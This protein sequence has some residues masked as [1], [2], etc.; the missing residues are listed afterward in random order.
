[1]L[2]SKLRETKPGNASKGDSST[3]KG[4]PESKWKLWILRLFALIVVPLFL[5]GGVEFIL[6]VSN[7]GHPTTFF[8]RTRV[9]GKEYYVPNEKFGLLYF[10][11]AL[12][13]SP[14]PLRM[15]VEKGSNTF[16]IFLFGES[17]AQG[18]PDPTY[19]MGRYLQVL[20]RERYPG[21]DFEVVCVAMTA[22]NSHA[23]LQIARE[24][25]G[26]QGDMWLIYMGNNEVVGPFGAGTVFGAKAPPLWLVRTSLA[27][28]RTKLGQAME[29]LVG[30]FKHDSAA[31]KSW[32]GM[33][34]FMDHQVRFD[35][36]ARLRVNH[37][38]ERNLEDI[39][40]A[41][42]RAGV[43][44]VLST[45]AS[46]LKDCAP[47]ASMHSAAF[48]ESRK[49]E[50]ETALKDGLALEG[51][52]DSWGAMQ[53]YSNAAAI[54]PQFA[55]I[56]FRLGT[57]HLAM[58]NRFW[59]GQAR[60]EFESA[61]DF[62]ALAF[63]ADSRI[64]QIIFDAAVRNPKE[65]VDLLDAA[66]L[67][68]TNSP[69]EI[70]GE[71]AFYEHVHLHFAGNYLLARAFAEHA[72]R[73]LPTSITADAKAEWATAD[74]C[75]R[76][77]GVTIWDR[78]RLWQNNMRRLFEAPFITQ[79]D[80]AIRVKSYMKKLEELDAQM[81]V[82]SPE[83]SRKIYEEALAVA[84]EDYYLHSNFGEF[85]DAIGDLP[86]AI[87]QQQGVRELLPLEPM[88][89]YKIGRALVR[90][91]KTTE[92]TEYF[93]RALVLRPD[94]VQAL[95]E[96][97]LLL[98]NQQK[99]AEAGPY[100]ERALHKDP[101]YSESYLN[102]GMVAQTQGKL[103]QAMA[104]Y[105]EAARLEVEGPAAYFFQGVNMAA[106]HR[107]DEAI[108]SFREAVKLKPGFWQ[109][110][111][112]LGVELAGANKVTD[113]QEQFESVIRLRPDYARAHLNLGVA[114]AKQGKFEPALN[115]FYTT[116]RLNPD[117]KLASQHIA[118]IQAMKRSGP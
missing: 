75:D 98:A 36:P 63:R 26:L 74:I 82:E 17:A 92:A 55:E 52:G 112:L 51:T 73:S 1:L 33:K 83:Q 70:P 99:W 60:R 57:C 14:L 116:L 37:S 7:F 20:L 108:Q 88:P 81:N 24:C 11:P 21:T 117:N 41:G 107:R 4:S 58:T 43:P 109:A 59:A 68:A 38:F 84:P 97:G 86:A 66:E 28:K 27:V 8:V 19:G 69:M 71:E 3:G 87:A 111:Y 110:S 53:R 23:V 89:N 10:P 118:T 77:L 39:L 22:I 62:D 44:I 56:Q 64:N 18:D 47:F 114:L 76:R 95:N 105:E 2:K 106:Q 12:V 90:Q 49:T 6:R 100:F 85:L 13:R 104:R 113:A 102:L 101:N 9:S 80:H 115:E 50:F 48:D 61:R 40:S 96:M 91:G 46:N 32:G 30:R 29:A 45:V 94:F 35:D 15:P 65:K 72:A 79:S 31:Q 67:L 5:L 103:D 25:A 93:R 42:R 16:R 34:M 78:R 54:D